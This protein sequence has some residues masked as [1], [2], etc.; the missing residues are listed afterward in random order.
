MRAFVLTIMLMLPSGIAFAE[1]QL[2]PPP[3]ILLVDPRV[4][5]EESVLGQQIVE[6]N[7]ADRAALQAEADAVS[8]A[9]EDEEQQLAARRSLLTRDA[10][11]VLATDF[12]RR[13]REA[14]AQQDQRAQ[15]LIAQ[16]EA[17]EREFSEQLTPIYAEILNEVG[18]AAVIDLRNV[19]LANA[20]LDISQEV[21][22]RLD[23]RLLDPEQPPE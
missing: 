22:R 12:D 23:L 2:R 13:V 7:R 18:G 11:A 20:R 16:I 6:D 15:E 10:F 9:F 17:R 21:I 8:E 14:R 3:A 5:L 4:I 1:E 19:I